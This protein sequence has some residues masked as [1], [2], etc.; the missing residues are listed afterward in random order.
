RGRTDLDV[1]TTIE[2]SEP[3]PNPEV[4]TVIYRVVQEA[5]TNIVKYAEAR[6]VAVSLVASDD[7]YVLTVVDDGSGFDIDAALETGL[8]IRG[9]RERADLVGGRLD[10]DSR[11]GA[12]TTV[13]LEI[14]RKAGH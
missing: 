14:P 11:P 10:V 3:R 5:L 2:V 9:M 8:G 6:S 4:E 1:T 12:G 13:V 7:A